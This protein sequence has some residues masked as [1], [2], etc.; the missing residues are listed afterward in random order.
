MKFIKIFY[1][2]IVPFG[3]RLLFRISC[4]P[5]AAEMLIAS[6]CDALAISAFGFS[7]DIADIFVLL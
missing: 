5:L 6:E 3:P 7:I 2:F 4:R 1:I